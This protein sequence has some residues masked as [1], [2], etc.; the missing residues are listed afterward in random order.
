MFLVFFN[1]FMYKDDYLIFED[2][3]GCVK[4]MGSVVLFLMYVIGMFSK[5]LFFI[6]FFLMNFLLV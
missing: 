6:L 5:F 3:S 2:E 1:K 4:L